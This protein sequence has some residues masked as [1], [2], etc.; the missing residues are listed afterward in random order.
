MHA[1]HFLGVGLLL[2]L[3]VV[4]GC[5]GSGSSISTGS[6][7]NAFVFIG[8]APPVGS[9]VLKFEITLSGAV[10]C[11]EVSGTGECLGSPQP[12]LINQPVE[13]ELEQLELESAFLNLASIPAGNYPNGGVKL[14]FANPELKL[15]LSDGSVTPELK[16]PLNP[17]SVTPKFSG[18]LTVTANTNFGFL[19]D[20][21]VSDSIQSSGNTVT[22]ISPMITLVKLPAVAQQNIEELEVTGK[23][24]NLSKN[25]PTGSFTLIESVTGLPIANIQF[26]GT[27]DF[28]DGLTCTNF[29]NDQTVELDL[30]LRAGANLQS[31]QFFAEEIEPVN[32]PNEKEAEGPVFQVN[33]P[34]QFVLVVR[35]EENA[36][37]LPLGSFLTVNILGSTQFRIDDDGLPIGSLSFANGNHLLAGQ[38]V[39]VDIANNTLVVPTAGCGTIGNCTATAEKVRLE[40][41]TITGRVTS[42][43]A[44]SFTIDQL[45]SIFGSA[46]TNLRPMS[47]DCQ[48]CFVNS[49]LVNT[50]SQTEFESPLAGVSGLATN[51]I[52]TVRGLLFKGG[53]AGPSPGSGQPTL[54]AKKVRKL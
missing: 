48:L 19:I 46:I 20:F 34:N 50:S 39:E 33:N 30:E 41:G 12:S 47:A 35:E 15:L 1:R 43:S 13:I 16:P 28:E 52:V 27:T 44:S 42:T 51:N 25:C 7:G 4:A 18:G 3:A 54:V 23:V 53:F 40:K 26:D 2:V 45:P 31:A 22:G 24:S 38:T 49:I 21:N 32:E 10:F 5:G 37:N 6:S 36:P 29:A 11:P 14:T 8:D 17:A 9:T